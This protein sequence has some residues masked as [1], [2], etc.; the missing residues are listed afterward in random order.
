LNTL[1]FTP[2]AEVQANQLNVHLKGEL[3]EL[4]S[5]LIE[6]DKPLGRQFQLNKAVY[7]VEYENLILL[8]KYTRISKHIIVYNIKCK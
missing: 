1:A 2:S 6:A 3:I 4:V 5:R 8:Y 7:E